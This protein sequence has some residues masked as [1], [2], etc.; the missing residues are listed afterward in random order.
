MCY[1]TV[2]T[3]TVPKVAFSARLVF[4]R[5]SL[6]KYLSNPISVC[7]KLLPQLRIQTLISIVRSPILGQNKTICVREKKTTSPKIS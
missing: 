4:L 5:I 6:K 2:V 7:L 1:V 3:A